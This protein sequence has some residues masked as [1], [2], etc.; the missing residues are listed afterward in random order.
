MGNEGQA[1]NIR[2]YRDSAVFVVGLPNGSC[3]RAAVSTLFSTVAASG[4]RWIG[5]RWGVTK[6]PWER[7]ELVIASVPREMLASSALLVAAPLRPTQDL[8]ILGGAPFFFFYPCIL[9]YLKILSKHQLSNI[10]PFFGSAVSL[11]VAPFSY[12]CTGTAAAVV[13][14][15]SAYEPLMSLC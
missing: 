3:W 9:T 13:G 4:R 14:A 2:L 8:A 12:L 5:R 7:R 1:V 11:F 10:A 6:W 15:D